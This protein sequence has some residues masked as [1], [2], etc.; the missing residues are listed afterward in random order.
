MKEVKYALV[1]V[2]FVVVYL[3][4]QSTK[5]SFTVWWHFFSHLKLWSYIHK[6]E[7]STGSNFLL[8]N[9]ICIENGK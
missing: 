5:I 8:Q 9:L 2:A 6:P 7:F 1:W 3:T 4:K